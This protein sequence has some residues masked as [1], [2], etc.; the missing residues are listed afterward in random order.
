MNLMLQ[1]HPPPLLSQSCFWQPLGLGFPGKA[2]M[3][4]SG[5]RGKKD[6]EWGQGGLRGKRA[7]VIRMGR[8]QA[9][10][11]VRRCRGSDGKDQRW[12]QRS[13]PWDAPVTDTCKSVYSSIVF[14]SLI[15]SADHNHSAWVKGISFFLL[16][17]WENWGM[18]SSSDLLKV[19]KF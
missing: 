16:G 5:E 2:K 18:E 11:A 8:E 19:A 12:A 13:R 10:S 7:K 6:I 1:P 15:S 4:P 14:M 3:S 9:A 17:W